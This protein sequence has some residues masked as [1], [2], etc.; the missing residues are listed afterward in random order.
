MILCPV[1][2]HYYCCYHY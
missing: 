1:T 2:H